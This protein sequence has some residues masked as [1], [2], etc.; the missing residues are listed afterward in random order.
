M[1]IKLDQTVGHTCHSS[2]Y[3]AQDMGL[4][5]FKETLAF[6]PISAIQCASAAAPPL[7]KGKRHL[8]KIL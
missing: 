1:R 2:T 6:A 7:L 4:F 3:I 8:S 5:N